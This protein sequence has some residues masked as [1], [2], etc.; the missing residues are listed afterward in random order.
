MGKIEEEVDQVLTYKASMHRR[1]IKR[2]AI[3]QWGGII[4]MFYHQPYTWNKRNK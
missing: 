2:T 1:E 4:Q 3:H